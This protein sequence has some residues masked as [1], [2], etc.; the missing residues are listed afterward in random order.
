ME[1]TATVQQETINNNKR[2]IFIGENI[3]EFIG[4]IKEIGK[5]RQV[6]QYSFRDIV[7]GQINYTNG[8]DVDIVF[9]VVNDQVSFNGNKNTAIKSLYDNLILKIGNVVK[10]LF[11]I[12]ARKTQDG[13]WFNSVTMWGLNTLDYGQPQQIAHAPVQQM[14]PMQQVAQ[15]QPQPQYQQF[16]QNQQPI[17]NGD[18]PF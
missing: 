8:R 13:K 11:S 1:Q 4:Q 17:D 10:V 18:M 5:A 12:N 16:P 15:P 14:Q 7:V 6:G 3:M 9:S 2:N